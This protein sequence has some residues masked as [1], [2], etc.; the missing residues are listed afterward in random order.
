MKTSFAQGGASAQKSDGV[1]LFFF[2]DTALF[3]TQS[4]A[5]RAAFPASAGNF[6]SGDFTGKKGSVA[7][8]YHGSGKQTKRVYLVG[9]GKSEAVSAEGIRRA[10]SAAARAAQRGKVKHISFEVPETASLNTTEIS[11]AIIEGAVLGVYAFDKYITKPADASKLEA[12]SLCTA[13][14]TI[15]PAVKAGLDFATKVS[16]GVYLTRDLANA[17][18]NEIYPETLA[19]R[20]QAA[21]KESGF[22]VT[23][24]DKK[25]IQALKMGGLLAVNQGSVRPPVF[26][27]M[28]Y[29]GGKK[30]EA[31][32]VLVGKGVTFDT[33]GISIK[34]A[35]GMSDMKIDMHGSATVI[36]AMSA[37]AKL[38]LPV[39]VIGLVPSTENMPSGTAFVPGDIVTH[40]N[41]K[42]SEID[43]TDAEGRLILADALTYADRY[44]PQAVI[45]IATLT[46]ACM[47]ALGSITSGLLGTDDVLKS[48]IKKA[49]Q[50]TSE[51]VCELPLYEDYEDQIKSD[52][53]DVKNSG[54]RPAG[55]ITAALFL[56]KFIG[57]YPWAHL[58]IAGTGIAPS[59]GPYSPKGGSGVGVR[60]F[61]D[62]LRNW[63]KDGG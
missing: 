62:M 60:L 11:E 51:H 48:R 13:N 31:P 12:V 57:D 54:G 16:Q 15:V 42:T 10:S 33:G 49:A 37:V 5:V 38:K 7:Q 36:G 59:A 44:K 6:D 25:K 24:L 8:C 26:I 45:D 52:V 17:P 35:P 41:G 30:G 27:V 18:N 23:V 63:K 61:V 40:M 19:K 2:E 56:K 34:P 20:A 29:M 28:E 14:K 46:G 4:A 39:N 53:A 58:D 22:K 47:I 32:V 43:N 55:T 21:G 1:A 9:L 3:T 50:R